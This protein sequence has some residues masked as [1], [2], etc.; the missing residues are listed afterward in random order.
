MWRER[1]GYGFDSSPLVTD[2]LAF[3]VSE[4]N[5][6]H[7]TCLSLFTGKKKWSFEMGSLRAAPLAFP[8]GLVILESGDVLGLFRTFPPSPGWSHELPGPC[9]GGMH[10]AG[11]DVLVA[12]GDSIFT[13]DAFSGARSAG[14]EASKVSSF[15]PL[16]GGGI[17]LVRRD[18]EL[19]LVDSGSHRAIWS[20]RIDAA[21]AYHMSVEDRR[22]YISSGETLSCLGSEGGDVL[23]ETRFPAPPAGAPCVVGDILALSTLE[24]KI[25]LLSPLSG[26]VLSTLDLKVPVESP[27]VVCAGTLVAASRHGRL[28]AFGRVHEGGG[29]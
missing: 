14:M 22:I 21:P 6:R 23:W 20:A 17:L 2:S 8:A 25:L 18:G 15:L 24:G 26:E 4:G 12:C 28:V 1:R 29:R 13:F 27:P 16:S 9:F 11:D 10:K 3:V 7:L 19:S 5:K